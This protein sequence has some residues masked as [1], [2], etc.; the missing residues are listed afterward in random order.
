MD[1]RFRS[2]S[3]R[4][5]KFQRK[6][7]ESNRALHMGGLSFCRLDTPNGFALPCG[8]PTKPYKQ[9]KKVPPPPEKDTLT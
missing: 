2:V 3:C 5:G 8:F 6:C 7:W 9:T 1:L 4:W